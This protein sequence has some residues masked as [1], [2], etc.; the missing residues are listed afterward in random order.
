MVLLFPN[1]SVDAGN[2]SAGVG[3]PVPVEEYV[4]YLTGFITVLLL[5]VWLSEYW[6][7]A[8][9]VEDYRG[10]ARALR[11]LLQFHPMSLVSGWR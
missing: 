11:R 4:F 8:Y 6:L 9:T 1:P 3:P 7:A 2:F 5:Y 10:E